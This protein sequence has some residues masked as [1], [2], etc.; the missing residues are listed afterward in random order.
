MAARDDAHDRR[1][2]WCVER[3]E[4]AT[5][6]VYAGPET[7]RGGSGFYAQNNS[8]FDAVGTGDLISLVGK[9]RFSDI[10][11]GGLDVDTLNLTDSNDAFFLHDSY[12]GFH[13]WL[14]LSPDSSG[15]DS[16]VRL[17]ELEVINAGAGDD[18][19]D[20]TSE[21]YSLASLDM[22]LNGGA[23]D[24]VLWAGHGDDI[25]DGGVG[26]DILN[27]GSGNDSLTGGSGADIFEFTIT[28][29]DD[30]ITDYNRAEGDVIKLY[31][32][33]G[34]PEEFTN[35][36]VVPDATDGKIIWSDGINQVSISFES[37]FTVSGLD[38]QYELI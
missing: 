26:M 3:Q 31:R 13:Q 22:T 10:L 25:L 27:G 21:D 29:G 34:F 38:I 33:E 35:A 11:D 20:M 14:E 16:H 5:C 12:S 2:S 9:T 8:Q 6:I 1:L 4:V 17:V 36:L 28:G 30:I 24:D 15:R 23:G 18:I 19:I 7:V 37:D 32:R